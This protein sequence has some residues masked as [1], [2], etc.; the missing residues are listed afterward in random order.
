MNERSQLR[1][2]RYE[3][4]KHG[5]TAEPTD[6]GH[7]AVYRDGKRVGTL[8]YTRRSCNVKIRIQHLLRDIGNK[9]KGK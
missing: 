7:I 9:E 1:E 4:K 8:A 2:M 3:L 6:N 5:I